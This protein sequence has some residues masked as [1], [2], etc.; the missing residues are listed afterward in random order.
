MQMTGERNYHVFYALCAGMR[1]PLKKRMGL[2]GT[3][4]DYFYLNQVLSTQHSC[5]IAL[6][7][8]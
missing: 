6:C 8:G 3:A 7:V 1:T 2:I 4:K 5:A